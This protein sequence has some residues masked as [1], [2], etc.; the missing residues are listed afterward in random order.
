M[1]KFPFCFGMKHPMSAQIKPER[2]KVSN[3]GKREKSN[4]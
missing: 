3:K 1:A 2:A 4:A